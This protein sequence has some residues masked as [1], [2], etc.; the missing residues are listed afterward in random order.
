MEETDRRKAKRYYG[1]GR[2]TP[3]EE[4]RT[5]IQY[6]TQIRTPSLRTRGLLWAKAKALETTFDQQRESSLFRM[7]NKWCSIQPM[8]CAVVK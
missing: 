5:P 3:A 8:Q 2:K 6:N 7:T 1:V 4:S